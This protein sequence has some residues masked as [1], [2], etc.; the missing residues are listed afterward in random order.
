[1]NFYCDDVLLD[2]GV[3]VSVHAQEQVV[4]DCVGVCHWFPLYDVQ[5][6]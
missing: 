6:S 3:N 5:R 1:M 4:D 2:C